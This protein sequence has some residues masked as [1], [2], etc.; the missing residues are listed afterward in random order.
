[1]P[2][3]TPVGGCKDLAGQLELVVLPTSAVHWIAGTV[4]HGDE[5]SSSPVGGEAQQGVW[6]IS[7][8]GLLLVSDTVP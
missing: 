2:P 6:R 7:E 8:S 4:P 3:V 1:M 5:E